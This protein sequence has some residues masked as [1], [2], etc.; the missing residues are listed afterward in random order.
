MRSRLVVLAAFAAIFVAVLVRGTRPSAGRAPPPAISVN[1]AGTLGNPALPWIAPPKKQLSGWV[2]DEAAHAVV[3]ARVCAFSLSIEHTDEES[4]PLCAVVGEDGRFTIEGVPA[5]RWDVVA[6]A[7]GFLP[8]RA[9]PFVDVDRETEHAP[10]EIHVSHGGVAVEGT[11]E[12]PL[13]RPVQGARVRAMATTQSTLVFPDVDVFTDAAG[14]FSLWLPEGSVDLQASA[15]GY[16]P[17]DDVFAAPTKK[18][19]LA[20]RWEAVLT[21]RV[22]DRAGIAVAGARVVAEGPDDEHTVRSAADGSFSFAGLGGG[23]WRVRASAPGLHG[24]LPSI[25]IDPGQRADGIVVVATPAARVSATVVVDDGTPCIDGNV[26]LTEPA[27]SDSAWSSTD[28]KGEVLFDAVSPGVW[29]VEVECEGT[30]PSGER[31]KVVV[32]QT[33]LSGLVFRVRRGLAA[34]GIVVDDDGAPIAGISLSARVEGSSPRSVSATSGKDGSFALA[35]LSQGSWLVSANDVRFVDVD[36]KIE[37]GAAGLSGLR[38]VASRGAQVHGKVV[39]GAGLPL[40]GVS[41]HIDGASYRDV[42]TLDDGTYRATGLAAGDHLVSVTRNGA[43]LAFLQP[44]VKTSEGTGVAFVAAKAGDQSLD[45]RVAA[46]NLSI[47]GRV[48]DAA[49]AAVAEASVYFRLEREDEAEPSEGPDVVLTDAEGRFVVTGLAEGKYTLRARSKGAGE[50]V[51][52]H[53]PAGGIAFMTLRPH[54]ALTA[55]IA[56]SV[57][58]ARVRLADGKRGLFFEET[59]VDGDRVRFD[60][61]PDGDYELTIECAEGSGFQKV[62]LDPRVEGSVVV[63]L[64]PWGAMTGTIPGTSPGAHV[65]LHCD[66]CAYPKYDSA[67]IVGGVFRAD[68]LLAGTYTVEVFEKGAFAK[69][70]VVVSAGQ[71]ATAVLEPIPSPPAAEPTNENDEAPPADDAAKEE[72]SEE[73]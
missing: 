25:L 43:R 35:G 66:D 3:L 59:I 14:K 49:G 65:S 46:P 51:S 41:V 20:L 8:A 27:S 18:A 54:V 58:T 70:T 16:A 63:S 11:V 62:V 26:R 21:G 2:V 37:I 34:R 4:G 50:V 6:S 31:P 9:D 7:N 45:L 5:G 36:T 29:D 71:T 1:T 53:V 61:I 28:A 15:T 55:T 38:I 32:A 72:Q 12:D 13:G 23:R 73:D 10:L 60:D 39:D 44:V 67:P 57:K 19:K 40:A 24:V 64:S 68:R 69:G 48:V 42:L 33:D 52:S 56:S 30:D 17:F 47:H 22:I